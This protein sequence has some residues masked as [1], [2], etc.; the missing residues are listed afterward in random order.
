MLINN[1]FSKRNAYEESLYLE[2]TVPNLLSNSWW[3]SG[4]SKWKENS[5][6]VE[7]VEDD[8]G[9]M[10]LMVDNDIS[11]QIKQRVSLKSNRSY[12]VM[13]DVQV[14][15]YVKGLFGVHFNGN[16]NSGNPSLGLRRVSKGYETIVGVLRTSENWH[17]QLVFS[18][19]IH[20][21][22]GAGSIRRLSLYDL[23]EFYGEGREPGAD[24]FY[25]VLPKKIDENG[26]HLS[27]RDIFPMLDHKINKNNLHT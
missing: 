14:T 20:N 11:C 10:N 23:T 5:G 22:N 24:E 19:S 16:F 1:D 8:E 17:P 25:K 9:F 21:A 4:I 12:F 18:G 13:F 3:T 27:L 2:N 7:L 6:Y 26:L 15:R